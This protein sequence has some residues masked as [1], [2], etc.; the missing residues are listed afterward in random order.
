MALSKEAAKNL[1]DWATEAPPPHPE[2]A[3]D[4]DHYFYG[5]VVSY[6][7]LLEYECLHTDYQ[8][9]SSTNLSMESRKLGMM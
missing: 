2:I 6:E 9:R 1:R 5:F 7:T 3:D 4:Y 8:A